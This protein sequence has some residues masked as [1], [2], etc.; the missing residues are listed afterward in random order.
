MIKQSETI[1]TLSDK[2]KISVIGAGSWGTTLAS[3]L[4][5][6]K[7]EITLWVYEKELAEIIRSQRVNTYYC[8]EAR[9]PE[10]V[11]ITTSIAE[12]A[13]EKDIILS[14]VPAQAVRSV[15]EKYI[16]NVRP[17]TVIVSASKGIENKTGMRI[18]Q[19][20]EEL[21][22]ARHIPLAV[23]SGPTFAHEI[24]KGLP[25]A[26][27]VACNN[28]ILGKQLQEILSTRTLRIYLNNDPIGVEFGGAVKNIVALAAGISDGLRFGYNTRAALM[29]RGLAEMIR[30]AVSVGAKEDTLRGL[31]GLGDLVLTCTGDLSRNRSVGMKIGQ[32][33]SIDAILSE[34][35][36]VAEGIETTRAVYTLAKRHQIE[37]PITEQVYAVLFQNKSPA[38][39][40]SDLMNRSLKYE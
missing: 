36:M 4:S 1:L 6:K 8:A 2:P 16:H 18:T 22:H 29:T 20:F 28:K 31:A 40:V 14:V 3:I 32:G 7:Y 39:A 23:L 26:A 37:M 27:V 34:M 13:E 9:L 33:K 38:T 25:A 10:N 17:G 12:A 35:N 11:T 24:I 21:M 5:Q 19:I 15:T 30:L